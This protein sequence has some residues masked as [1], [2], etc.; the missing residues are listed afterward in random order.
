MQWIK[1]ILVRGKFRMDDPHDGQKR[2]NGLDFVGR[3]T[4]LIL[5]QMDENKS[6]LKMKSYNFFACLY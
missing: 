6:K 5:I 3:V 2:V 4:Q 1:R